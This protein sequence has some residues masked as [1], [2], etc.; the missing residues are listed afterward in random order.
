VSNASIAAER[1]Q[2]EGRN[3]MLALADCGHNI[4]DVYKKIIL[5]LELTSAHPM[6]KAF[7]QAF[8]V[9]GQ[10][11]PVGNYKNVPGLGV[12]GYIFGKYYFLG[13]AGFHNAE[14]TCALY[15]DERLVYQF[16]FESV[17]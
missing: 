7:R 6:A 16:H 11:P 10:L 2:E 13:N 12:S 5:A 14:V 3:A 1:L 17:A 8:A 9:N 4:P 15:E